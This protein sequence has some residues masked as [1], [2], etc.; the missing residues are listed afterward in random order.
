LFDAEWTYRRQGFSVVSSLPALPRGFLPRGRFH[1]FKP[2]GAPAL[3]NVSARVT[4]KAKQALN[5]LAARRG[6]SVNGLFNDALARYLAAELQ[7]EG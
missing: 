2:Q 5:E 1:R 6:I 7:P 4:P 3:V